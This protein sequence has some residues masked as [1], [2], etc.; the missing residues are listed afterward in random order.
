MAKKDISENKVIPDSE[1]TGVYIAKVE[2]G[3]GPKE[4][5]RSRRL[6]RKQGV[7]AIPSI[8][9]LN[10]ANRVFKSEEP[11]ETPSL[12]EAS[13]TS[14]PPTP[15]DVAV[16]LFSNLLTTP[17]PSLSL[18]SEDSL[19][20][21]ESIDL[22][23]ELLDAHEVEVSKPN[24]EKSDSNPNLQRNIIDVNT[25]PTNATTE[26]RV[27]PKAPTLLQNTIGFLRRPSLTFGLTLGT[28]L[29][30]TGFGLP[31]AAFAFAGSFGGIEFFRK[32]SEAHAKKPI[33]KAETEAPTPSIS[34]NDGEPIDLVREVLDLRTNSYL[35]GGTPSPSRSPSPSSSSSSSSSTFSF[36]R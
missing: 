36:K 2:T 29:F 28:G 15:N 5:H 9:S 23:P 8:G 7:N 14:L 17:P 4:V 30:L 24:N 32:I 11:S 19:P 6:A 10:E 22:S 1:K 35:F 33:N 27:L 12:Q 18:S 20:S 16:E 3:K 21:T 13:V 26:S 25:T 34:S 31:V